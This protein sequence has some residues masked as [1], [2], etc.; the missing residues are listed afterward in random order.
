MRDIYS[1]GLPSK[2]EGGGVIQVP[3]SNLTGGALLTLTLDIE[4]YRQPGTY[5][6]GVQASFQVSDGG[7]LYRWYAGGT[8]VTV[9][10][11]LSSATLEAATLP[12]DLGTPASGTETIGGSIACSL[13]SS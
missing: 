5:T 3:A 4:Q 13:S 10:Q 1:A 6:E 11:N 12:A 9:A 2:L 8:T 7:I